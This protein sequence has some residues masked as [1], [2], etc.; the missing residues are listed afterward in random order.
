MSHPSKCFSP[1]LTQEKLPESCTPLTHLSHTHMHTQA[2]TQTLLHFSLLSLVLPKSQRENTHS[3]SSRFYVLDHFLQNKSRF[4]SV[5]CSLNHRCAHSGLRL[6]REQMCNVTSVVPRHCLTEHTST[7]KHL[8]EKTHFI[9]SCSPRSTTK[10]H[11]CSAME[12]RG[13]IGVCAGMLRCEEER[14]WGWW[15]LFTIW[16]R[17]QQR[18]S[19]ARRCC[20]WCCPGSLPC[21]QKTEVWAPVLSWTPQSPPGRPLWDTHTGSSKERQRFR[22]THK[23]AARPQRNHAFTSLFPWQKQSRSLRDRPTDGCALGRGRLPL[24]SQTGAGFELKS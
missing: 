23:V 7:P 12:L 4:K 3:E 21:C 19:P 8:D 15:G 11:L 16:N 14:W 13:T 18:A 24:T 6:S 22:R 1:H 10:E 20:R 2:R 17:L 5:S 9:P